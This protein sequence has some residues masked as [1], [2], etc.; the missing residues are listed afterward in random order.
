MGS[1]SKRKKNDS[2]IIARPKKYEVGGSRSGGNSNKDEDINQ[3]CI[4]S[5]DVNLT[6]S[7]LLKRNA[8]LLLN[9]DEV[10]LGATVVGTLSARQRKM[11]EKC[12]ENGFVYQGSVMVEK[13][14]EKF[15][16]RFFR[17]K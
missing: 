17:G 14:T 15:Y 16:G 3:I 9:K 6:Q 5:F 10:L 8:M 12:A 7:P 4:S 1:T 11:V 13:K 2:I